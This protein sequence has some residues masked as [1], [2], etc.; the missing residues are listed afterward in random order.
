MIKLKLNVALKDKAKGD[1][2]ELETDT[3]NN[4]KDLYWARRLEDA[5]IDNCVEIV[6]EAKTPESKKKTQE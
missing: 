5:A 1:I 4:I 6:P 3:E 2:I